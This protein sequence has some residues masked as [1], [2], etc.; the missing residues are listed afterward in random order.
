[1]SL[2]EGVLIIII[3]ILTVVILMRRQEKRQT[4]TKTWDCVDRDSGKIS[5]VKMEYVKPKPEQMAANEHAEYFATCSDDAAIKDSLNAVCAKDGKFEYAKNEYGGLGRDYK[6][7]VMNQAI[8]AAVVNNHSEFVKDRTGKSAIWTGRTYTP[9]QLQEMEG[10]DTVPW[11][12]IR[13][14]PQNVKICDP[15]QVPDFNENSY[16]DKAKLSWT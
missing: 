11:A 13:G 9:E 1:M 5:T 15:T 12:G 14:R 6:D 10:S 4:S 3:V 2:T 7:Y 8:D 16:T